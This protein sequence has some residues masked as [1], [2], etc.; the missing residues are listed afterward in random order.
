MI[1]G[2]FESVMIVHITYRLEA[3]VGI[4]AKI[5]KHKHQYNIKLFKQSLLGE[6]QSWCN[7]E[8]ISIG[9]KGLNVV[10]VQNHKKLWLFPIIIR[11]QISNIAGKS[12][13]TNPGISQQFVG[14]NPAIAALC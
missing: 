2:F 12:F 3:I 9:E 5:S 14:L 13:E 11:H 10:L 7:F 8:N 1:F 4:S 6:T